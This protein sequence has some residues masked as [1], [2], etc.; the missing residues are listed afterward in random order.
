M[1]SGTHAQPNNPFDVWRMFGV[2]GSQFNFAET[3]FRAWL[4]G[5]QRVQAEATEFFNVRSGKD[6]AALSELIQC[7][8]PAEALEM[9]ARYAGD[10]MSDLVAQSQRM[11]ALMSANAQRGVAIVK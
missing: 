11:F 3:A 9:Q 1:N 8:T 5:A 2:E 4:D 10:A 7:K 6:M